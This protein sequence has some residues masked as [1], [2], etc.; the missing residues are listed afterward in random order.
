[1]YFRNQWLFLSNFYPCQIKDQGHQFL[2]VEAAYQAAK[3]KDGL[4]LRVAFQH[5]SGGQAK[6]LVRALKPVT[7][8]PAFDDKKLRV[9]HR[10]L[11]QKF[12]PK[13]R[14]ELADRLIATGDTDLVE[15]NDWG[16]T[17]WGRCN[18]VGENHLGKLLMQIRRTLQKKGKKVC[19]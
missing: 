9:M 16:D 2:N 5:L 12:N 1:M 18:G 8:D 7:L 4:G 14:S 19:Q 17:F 11:L 6:Q 3:L 10:L 15:D 13:S